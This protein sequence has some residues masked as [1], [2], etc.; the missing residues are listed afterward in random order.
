MAKSVEKLSLNQ[1]QL[2]VAL[3][4]ANAR[5]DKYTKYEMFS[6]RAV[7]IIA[8]EEDLK[9]MVRNLQR[10]IDS[11]LQKVANILVAS[12]TGVIWSYALSQ[13]ELKKVA[14][15]AYANNNITLSTAYSNK[16]MKAVVV[17]KSPIMDESQL[18]NNNHTSTESK[19]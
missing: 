16:K 10:L 17:F 18:H 11:F 13:E 2:N 12:M 8:M 7:S 3:N 19:L 4:T 6:H 9:A 14:S 15:D 1:E 5:I